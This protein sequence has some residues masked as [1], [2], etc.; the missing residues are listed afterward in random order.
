MF[1]YNVDTFYLQEI[2]CGSDVDLFAIPIKYNIKGISVDA[3]LY[4]FLDFSLNDFADSRIRIDCCQQD[5]LCGKSNSG[6]GFLR[7]F[8]VFSLIF[9]K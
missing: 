7:S 9:H 6:Y 2:K 5:L 1:Y 4:P 3:C 8:F